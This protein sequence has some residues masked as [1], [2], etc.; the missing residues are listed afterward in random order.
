[1]MNDIQTQTDL[2]GNIFHNEV[3]RKHASVSGFLTFFYYQ[4]DCIGA[5]VYL[6]FTADGNFAGIYTRVLN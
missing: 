3:N 4:P 1:M 6:S 2:V 5:V